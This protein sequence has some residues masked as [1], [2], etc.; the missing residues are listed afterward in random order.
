MLKRTSEVNRI[1]GLNRDSINYE[2]LIIIFSYMQLAG[3]AF[4]IRSIPW[5]SNAL[6]PT[7]ASFPSFDFSGPTFEILSKQ[8]RITCSRACYINTPCTTQSVCLHVHTTFDQPRS[9]CRCAHLHLYPD[10]Y[11]H[12]YWL[13]LFCDHDARKC[14]TKPT[15]RPHNTYL[16]TYT[17]TPIATCVPSCFRLIICGTITWRTK[18]SSAILYAA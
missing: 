11:A 5:P 1:H 17:L 13:S 18:T 4:D 8:G 9:T 2:Y 3:G 14:T 15:A 6:F 16:G 12:G 10:V 7:L